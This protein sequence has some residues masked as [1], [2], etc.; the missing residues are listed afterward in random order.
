M[1]RVPL[2]LRQSPNLKILNLEFSEIDTLDPLLPWLIEFT[3]LEELNLYGNRLKDL[4]EDL[5]KLLNLKKIDLNNNFFS[6]LDAL[7]LSLKSLPNLIDL[8]YTLE[9]PEAEDKILESLPNLRKF[10]SKEIIIDNKHEITPVEFTETI[11]YTQEDISLKQEEL[12]EIALI[13]D[14]L[15]SLWREIEPRSDKK[16]A[17]YFDSNIKNI[18]MELSEIH[19]QSLSPHLL[20]CYT[21]KAKYSFYNICQSKAMQYVGR[22]SKKLASIFED[23]HKSYLELFE[24]AISMIFSFC[25]DEKKKRKMGLAKVFYAQMFNLEFLFN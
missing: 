21:L 19:K 20:H 16:L 2:L 13:Y 24:E 12:E 11:N 5:S 10:N 25:Q 6:S 15:R 4:P 17:E 14:D 9:N 7:I 18:M 8:Q 23:I 3:E 1:N 22:N